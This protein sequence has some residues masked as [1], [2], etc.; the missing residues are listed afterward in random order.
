MLLEYFLT[1]TSVLFCGRIGSTE[2]ASAGIAQS[3][4]SILC[5]MPGYGMVTV[6]NTYFSVAF[7]SKDDRKQ[8]I[9]L[10]KALL[11]SWIVSM[12]C[13]AI[14]INTESI[15]RLLQQ[16]EEISILAGEFVRVY[17]PAVPA[18]FA[19]FVLSRYLQCRNHVMVTMLAL[20]FTA[21]VNI[22]L[23]YV[24]VISMNGG[25]SWSAGSL[26]I[27]QYVYLIIIIAYTSKY[28]EW[29]GRM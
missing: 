13:W 12:L 2:M 8:C 11:L 28:V 27:S 26:V 5:F 7:G 9:I 18:M 24:F 16:K 17:L 6:C 14:L 25:T 22:I 29:T 1:T 23:N 10:Q 4:I 21:I 15:L 20:L 3:I 19:S